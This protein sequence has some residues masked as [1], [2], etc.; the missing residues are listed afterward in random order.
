MDAHTTA[1]LYAVGESAQRSTSLN[2]L[3][4][5]GGVH[6]HASRRNIQAVATYQYP[7]KID[8]TDFDSNVC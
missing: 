6:C 8:M 4:G 7:L 3:A 2:V 1:V 5:A